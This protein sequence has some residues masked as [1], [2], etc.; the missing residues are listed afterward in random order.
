MFFKHMLGGIRL[1]AL[2]SIH[3]QTQ[4]K[5]CHTKGSE[6]WFSLGDW[7]SGIPDKYTS[8]NHTTPYRSE[9]VPLVNQEG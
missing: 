7:H 6:T 3:L 5:I 1:G 2:I 4:F 9:Q 8:G